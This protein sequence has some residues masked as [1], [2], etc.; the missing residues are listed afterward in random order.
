M[1]R[2]MLKII[3][4][5]VVGVMDFYGKEIIGDGGRNGFYEENKLFLR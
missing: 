3:G 4:C 1:V 2:V 5:L